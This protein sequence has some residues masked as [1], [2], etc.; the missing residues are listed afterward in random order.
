MTKETFGKLVDCGLIVAM[1][2]YT[3]AYQVDR[4]EGLWGY[5]VIPAF[6]LATLSA[7]RAIWRRP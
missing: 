5:V 3:V 4:L 1:L 2:A 6:G 7:V